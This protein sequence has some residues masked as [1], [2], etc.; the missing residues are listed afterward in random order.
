L[1]DGKETAWNR[2]TTD[3]TVGVNELYAICAGFWHPSQAELTAPYVDRYFA[4][5]AGTAEIR[6][7]IAVG[8]AAG[9]I[10]PRYAVSATAVAQA[11]SLI[12]DD[13]VPPGIRRAVA[14]AA[15]DLERALEART[16]WTNL[17]R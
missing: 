4:D 14:D 8:L 3:P 7:G 6:A 2:V 9:R 10:F 12:G 17:S 16:L 11:E 5:I 13:A 1:P 15:D